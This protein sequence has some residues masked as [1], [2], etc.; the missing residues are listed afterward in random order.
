V[1]TKRQAL[2]SDDEDFDESTARRGKRPV[3]KRARS[4]YSAADSL[5]MDL[6]S[7]ELSIPPTKKAKTAKKIRRAAVFSSDEGEECNE[8]AMESRPGS[9][10]LPSLD[11]S[12]GDYDHDLPPAHSKPVRQKNPTWKLLNAERASSSV[13]AG[14]GVKPPGGPK[15]G[16]G[17]AKLKP[18]RK[19]IIMKD[20]RKRT[21]TP[22]AK[23]EASVPKP[24]LARAPPQGW[25]HSQ[26][27]RELVKEEEEEED[28]PVDDRAPLPPSSPLLPQ[29]PALP[30]PKKEVLAPSSPLPP[31]ATAPAPAP[32][33]PVKKKLPTIKKNKPPAPAPC[34]TSTSQSQSQSQGKPPLPPSSAPAVGS[35][36]AIVPQ[37]APGAVARKTPTT[38]D[39]DLQD[40][41]TWASI[42]KQVC[43]LN[44]FSLMTLMCLLYLKTGVAPS[45]SG[46]SRREK[47]EERRKELCR[48]R[49]E[50]RAKREEALVSVFPPSIFHVC[51]TKYTVENNI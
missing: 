1:A 16:K 4:S 49:D 26:L 13:K 24:Q 19:E 39:F 5:E 7:P 29:P 28:A 40:K 14:T 51:I 45:R 47:D 12:D 33:A 2:Q 46:L 31:S 35:K 9:S 18:V 25:S 3:T 50:A 15:V 48:M 23:R 22:P 6:D 32:I 11:L 17:G 34:S 43:F 38:T 30:P 44:S 20:E 36:N 21:M 8:E 41:S 37:S 10:P 42:F 27:D